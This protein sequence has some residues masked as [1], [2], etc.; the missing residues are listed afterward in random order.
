MKNRTNRINGVPMAGC[1]SVF[2]DRFMRENFPNSVSKEEPMWVPFEEHRRH[3]DYSRMDIY[4]GYIADVFLNGNFI[5]SID[6]KSVLEVK[7]R[8]KV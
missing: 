2:D 5:G 8:R 7:C 4:D 1:A 6:S 3:I